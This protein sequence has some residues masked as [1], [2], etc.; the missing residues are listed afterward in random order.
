MVREIVGGV[1]VTP[2]LESVPEMVREQKEIDE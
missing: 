2:E 1:W